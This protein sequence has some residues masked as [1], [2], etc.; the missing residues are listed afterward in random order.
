MGHS[1]GGH[2]LFLLINRRGRRMR[3][4]EKFWENR[5]QEGGR[6]FEK[7]RNTRGGKILEKERRVVTERGAR[8][9]K[10]EFF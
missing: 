5:K 2:L 6:F 7:E 10:G 9:E 1:R 4:G 3:W 8:R